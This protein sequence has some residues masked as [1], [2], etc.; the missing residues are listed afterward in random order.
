[1]QGLELSLRLLPIAQ[2]WT[3]GWGHLHLNRGGDHRGKSRQA[4]MVGAAHCPWLRLSWRVINRRWLWLRGF[5]G[6]KWSSSKH[7]FI[8]LQVGFTWGKLRGPKEQGPP[9]WIDRR[10]RWGWSWRRS[11]GRRGQFPG[12]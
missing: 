10:R 6:P 4:E 11:R 8:D 3:P 5:R 2:R 9:G 7:R 12:Q 1:M